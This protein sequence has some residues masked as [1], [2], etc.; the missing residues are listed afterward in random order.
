VTATGVATSAVPGEPISPLRP[1]TAATA[2]LT[3]TAARV[4]I[5]GSGPSPLPTPSGFSKLVS[6]APD[7]PN[8]TPLTWSLSTS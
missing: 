5:V 3:P 4:V 7:D 1:L 6:S 8:L 2:P